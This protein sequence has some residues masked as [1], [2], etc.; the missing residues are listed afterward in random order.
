MNVMYSGGPASGHK[1]VSPKVKWENG[2]TYII[3]R[4]NNTSYRYEPT[5]RRAVE[6]GKSWAEYAYVG[7]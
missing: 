6:D 3:V 7:G 5:G 1:D 4:L 2:K